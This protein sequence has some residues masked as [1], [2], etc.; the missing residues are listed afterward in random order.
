MK[1]LVRMLMTKGAIDLA[2]TWN[3]WMMMAAMVTKMR[4]TAVSQMRVAIQ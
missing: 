3:A 2:M 4:L 1:I